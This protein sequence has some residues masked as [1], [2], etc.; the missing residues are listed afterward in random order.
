[1]EYPEPLTMDKETARPPHN[2]SNTILQEVKDYHKKQIYIITKKFESKIPSILS[3]LQ[4]YDNEIL[5]KMHIIKYLISLIQNIPY[6]LDLISAQKSNDEKQKL[7]LYEILINEYIFVEKN[8]K[9]Y[10]QLLKDIFFLIF[11]KLS[12]NKDI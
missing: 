10:I 7:N 3:Y 11:K 8:E 5:N 12:L 6:N 2:D 4:N 1:M 9:E